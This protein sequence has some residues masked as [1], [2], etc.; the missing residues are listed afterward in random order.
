MG[1]G[2]LFEG[3]KVLVKELVLVAEG[4]NLVTKV[5]KGF[6]LCHDMMDWKMD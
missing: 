1:F 5:R 2:F 6:S 3:G 4:L